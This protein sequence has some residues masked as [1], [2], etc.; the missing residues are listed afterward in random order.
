[1]FNKTYKDNTDNALLSYQHAKSN[2]NAQPQIV[3]NNDFK[4]LNQLINP[5][6]PA[7]APV[8]IVSALPLAP[9]PFNPVSK[10]D[11]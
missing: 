2:Q 8:P 3:I 6:A 4:G 5:N 11:T 9:K 1:M 10:N 7:A